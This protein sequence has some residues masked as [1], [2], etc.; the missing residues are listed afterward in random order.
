MSMPAR[1]AKFGPT[2]S[3]VGEPIN[4]QPNGDS[5][6]WISTEG[7]PLADG[8]VVV[9]DGHRLLSNS[10]GNGASARVDPWILASPGEKPIFLERRYADRIERSNVV[11]L[12]V[13]GQPP[14]VD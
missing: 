2:E 1:I 8:T 3:R 10:A 14:Q 7:S 4:P 12:E 13:I 5:A 6:V 9:M 11:Y